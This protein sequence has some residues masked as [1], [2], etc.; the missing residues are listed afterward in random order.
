L[1]LCFSTVAAS[2]D[3]ASGGEQSAIPES[4][5]QG[6]ASNSAQKEHELH[7]IGL[8]EPLEGPAFYEKLGRPDLVEAYRNREQLKNGLKILGGVTTAV[9]LVLGIAA[10]SSIG[11]DC[12]STPSNWCFGPRVSKNSQLIGGLVGL[13]LVAGGTGMLV[14]GFV[15]NPNPVDAVEARQLADEYNAKLKDRLGVASEFA[16]ARQYRPPV[17]ISVAPML[18]T[19]TNGIALQLS[20]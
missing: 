18:S 2:A 20:F 7:H 5:S 1:F 16:P 8:L 11:S 4:L 3:L 17:R 14:A 10:V 12:V 9:G 15:I 6:A 13:G 19:S